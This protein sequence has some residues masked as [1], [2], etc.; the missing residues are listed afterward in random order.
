MMKISRAKSP[1]KAEFLR[2]D[3]RFNS[4]KQKWFSLNELRN[5][6]VCL[7]DPMLEIC[8][9]VNLA[10]TGNISAINELLSQGIDPNCCNYSGSTA[11]HMAA[12][13]KH[14][15]IIELLV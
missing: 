15:E 6:G 2:Y 7:E 5:I 8:N 4:I 3:Y 11:M 10:S 12:A 1:H 13:N 14:T 9:F